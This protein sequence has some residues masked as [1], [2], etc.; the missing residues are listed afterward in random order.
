MIVLNGEGRPTG[1]RKVRQRPLIRRENRPWPRKPHPKPPNPRRPRAGAKS[2][3]S[4]Q[5]R[6]RFYAELAEKTGLSKKQVS[7]VFDA[8]H[9][10]SRQGAR[11]EGARHRSDPRPA[12][13]QGR[14]QAGDQG[15]CRASTRPPSSRSRSRPSRPARS[16]RSCRSRPSRTSSDPTLPADQPRPVSTR[17]QPDATG[18]SVRCRCCLPDRVTPRSAPSGTRGCG[19]R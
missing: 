18:S 10:L 15:P 16:S 4:P 14:Q 17:R 8:M 2:A 6:P 3:P 12:Q 5:P 9:E 7:A 19:R 11:Q 13:D 1:S